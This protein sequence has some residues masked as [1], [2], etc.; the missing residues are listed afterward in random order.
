VTAQ[1]LNRLS[2]MWVSSISPEGR[3]KR[4]TRHRHGH[5]ALLRGD[6]VALAHVGYW[7]VEHRDALT[8]AI[9]GH[10][11]GD[12]RVLE[13]LNRAG[14]QLALVLDNGTPLPILLTEKR[15]DGLTWEFIS[16]MASPIEFVSRR[17]LR[18]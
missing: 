6:D 18:L 1:T 13:S 15:R 9:S 16:S 14:E 10:V 8:C 4:M 17:P 11:R 3:I 5:G 7:I 2:V 12:I